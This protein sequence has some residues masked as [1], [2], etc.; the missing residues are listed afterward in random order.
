MNC[1]L[2]GA[3]VSDHDTACSNCGASLTIQQPTEPIAREIAMP[4]A[5]K[6]K[7]DFW[8][9][10]GDTF[11]LYFRNL[12]T[13][14]LVGLILIGTFVFFYAAKMAVGYVIDHVSIE[15]TLLLTL[16]GILALLYILEFLAQ[17]YVALG[18][19]RQCLYIARGGIGFQATLM[20]PPLMPF[21]KMVGLDLLI[22]CILCAVAL[23][24][25]V[26]ILV[27]VMLSAQP[28]ARGLVL[29]AVLGIFIC[30]SVWLAVR[31]WFSYIVLADRDAGIIDSFTTGWNISLGNFWRLLWAGIVFGTLVWFGL[32]IFLV[33]II[34]TMAIA[35]FGGVI[36]YLQLTGQ[37][38]CLDMPAEPEMTFMEP[39]A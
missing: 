15:D 14:C 3:N 24:V 21:V 2:C 1:Q 30:I 22:R 18:A 33:G 32:L 31:L 12:G 25:F 36:A 29:L 20:F 7:L 38:N 9:L 10:F 27:A 35:W 5:D 28:G 6:V 23:A 34:L 16:W 26:P 13:F 11:T 17:C 37:P 19:I 8:K 39:E 4:G